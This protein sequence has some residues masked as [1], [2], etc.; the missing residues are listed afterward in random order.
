MNEMNRGFRQRL[1]D[2]E[3][4]NLVLKERYHKELQAMFEKKLSGARR[5]VWLGSVIL[6]AVFT[7]QFGTLAVL[8]PSGFPWWGRL[9]FVGGAIFGIGWAVLGVKILRRGSIDLKFDATMYNGMIWGFVV[10]MVTLSMVFA[11]QNAVGLRM[12]VTAL[13]F[14]VMGAVFLIRHVVEQSELKTREKLLEIEY[15][16]AELAE[17]MKPERPLPPTVQG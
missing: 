1:L 7:L 11:P 6:G 16:L 14:L 4:V 9:M 10:F 3:Q 5:W 2:A 17:R 15:S 13:V 8:A 12:I